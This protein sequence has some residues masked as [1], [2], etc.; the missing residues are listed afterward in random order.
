MHSE[1]T[2]TACDTLGEITTLSRFTG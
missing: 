2:Q 1:I